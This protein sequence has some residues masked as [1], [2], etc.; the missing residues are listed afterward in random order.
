LTVIKPFT[1]VNPKEQMNPQMVKGQTEN[2]NTGILTTQYLENS[3]LG[4]AGHQT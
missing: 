2:G 1:L 4:R 3:L